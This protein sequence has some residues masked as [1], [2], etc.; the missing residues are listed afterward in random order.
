MLNRKLLGTVA[1]VLAVVCF[2]GTYALSQDKPAAKDKAGAANGGAAPAGMDDA[3]MKAFMEASAVGPQHKAL[4]AMAGKF[5]YTNKFKMDPSQ[6]WTTSEGDYEGEMALGGRFLM[7]NVRGP[8]MGS[9]FEGMGCLGYDNTLK[10]Y[11]AGWID[12]MSTGVMRSE[13]TS[14]DNGKTITFAGEMM[15]A[16]EHTMKQYKYQYEIKS[17][18]EFTMRWWAP[19][20]SDG[21]MFESMVI[22]YTRVK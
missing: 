22:T 4:E 20:M 14:S 7:S 5:K 1:A 2:I 17:N 11:V 8:M 18:D 19:G 10:K 12:N 3:M 21:K 15:C 16:I 9:T 13:G 6:E